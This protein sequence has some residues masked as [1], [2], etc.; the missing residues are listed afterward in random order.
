MKYLKLYEEF[1]EFSEPA[2]YEIPSNFVRL[3]SIGHVLDPEE[4]VIYAMWKK[5]GYD[6][7]NPYE[8]GDDESLEGISDEDREIVNKY[9]L[10]CESFVKDKINWDLIQTAKDIALDYL[11]EIYDL[12]LVSQVLIESDEKDEDDFIDY[13]VYSELFSHS[14]DKKEF[15]KWFP[16]RMKVVKFKSELIYRFWFV[17]KHRDNKIDEFN[18]EIFDRLNEIFPEEN[19]VSK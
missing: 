13:L 12:A 18:K 19:I 6:H 10:S 11:D 4:G 7:E 16:K 17:G 8:V 5:G 1:E 3:D 14:Y 2:Y 9:L 15:Q